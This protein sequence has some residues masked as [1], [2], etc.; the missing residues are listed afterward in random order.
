MKQEDLFNF[1]RELPQPLGMA[2]TKPKDIIRSI[3]QMDIESDYS[4]LVYF[5]MLLFKAMR[6]VYGSKGMLTP[7]LLLLNYER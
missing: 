6:R 3:I 4:G 5:H 2:G 1:F 7:S